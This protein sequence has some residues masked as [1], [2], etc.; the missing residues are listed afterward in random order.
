[1]RNKRETYGPEGVA[2]L[3]DVVIELADG[4][5]V[6]RS[7]GD[8]PRVAAEVLLHRIIEL[9]QR[10]LQLVPKLSSKKIYIRNIFIRMLYEIFSQC[11]PAGY[12]VKS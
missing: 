8:R 6:L 10:L 9:D 11:L 2:D 12:G 5:C 7:A 1:M 3:C 4:L